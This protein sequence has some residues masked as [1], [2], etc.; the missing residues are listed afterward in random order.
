MSIISAKTLIPAFVLISFNVYAQQPVLKVLGKDSAGVKLTKL[1]TGVKVI[2][3]YAVTTME[4]VF[5]NSTQYVLEGELIFPMP[6]GV[7]VSRYAID[8]NG[9]M[10]EAVPVEKEKGQVV[11]ENIERR[12]IDPGCKIIYQSIIARNKCF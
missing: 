12:N 9:K 7:S 3:N 10:R 4:M 2:G 11:F 8:I 1:K 6:D 5:C